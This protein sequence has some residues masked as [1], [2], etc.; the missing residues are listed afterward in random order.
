M[1]S[2]LTDG[3]F[4]LG[5]LAITAGL[6]AMR[7]RETT[8]GEAAAPPPAAAAAAS[9]LV[10][11]LGQVW[12]GLKRGWWML[13]AVAALIAVVL[14]LEPSAPLALSLLTSIPALAALGVLNLCV[15]L[16][17]A[18]ASLDAW[19]AARRSHPSERLVFAGPLLVAT[20]GVIV[21]PHVLA[22]AYGILYVDLVTN[23]FDTTNAPIVDEER[24]NV[25]LIGIDEGPG[26]SGARADSIVL[27]SVN[28]DD[29]S[30]VLFSVSRNLA[31]VPAPQELQDGDGC[32]TGKINS[33]WEAAERQ[34]LMAPGEAGLEATGYAVERLLDIEIHHLAAVNLRG[35]V[36]LVDALGGLTVN[37]PER[38]FDATYPHEDGT[39]EVIDIPAGPAHLDGHSTL[40]FMRSRRLTD[41]Y[42]R[43]ARQQLV[44][45]AVASQVEAWPLVI[46]FPDITRALDEHLQTDIPLG[47]VPRLV[48]LFANANTENTISICLGPPQ[49]ADPMGDRVVPRVDAIRHAV[50]TAISKPPAVAVEL[51]DLKGD[52]SPCSV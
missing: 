2:L 41:D 32:Y 37:V 42:D 12:L 18:A 50:Q 19:K 10:P 26:R 1:A 30:A 43:I 6:I 8:S 31:C 44:L 4:W 49:W 14:L 15:L 20:I 39:V 25:L 27:A 29:G 45:E 48:E 51:L 5:I 46:R 38:I 40:A 16:V 3:W 23:V 21:L 22:T 34:S 9:A 11:G 17:R 52:R 7:R 13:A 33:L 35:V 24:L 47:E 28:R 36:E